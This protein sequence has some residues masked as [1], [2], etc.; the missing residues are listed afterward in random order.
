MKLT[1]K[2]IRQ[3]NGETQEETAKVLGV[4]TQ[5]YNAYENFKRDTPLEQAV[6]FSRH[7][8]VDLSDIIFFEKELI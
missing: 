4:S 8:Q 5:S 3:L 7:F 6:L 2:Q 1:M